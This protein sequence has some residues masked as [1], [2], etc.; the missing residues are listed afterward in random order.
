MPL[1]LPFKSYSE[2]WVSMNSATTVHTKE[3]FLYDQN[4]VKK[5]FNIQNFY[6]ILFHFFASTLVCNKMLL[7]CQL[8]KLLSLR[9]NMWKQIQVFWEQRRLLKPAL[10]Q[11]R[12]LLLYYI[13]SRRI[14]RV[15]GKGYTSP[16]HH[17]P[18]SQL[19][20]G[21][22]CRTTS[23]FNILLLYCF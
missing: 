14:R 6:T 7:L 3:H 20:R 21:Q 8:H 5:T 1:Y 22:K 15:A 9:Y 4:R 12:I 16:P 13:C 17:H 10:T 19:I 18:L 23:P 2:F 11:N